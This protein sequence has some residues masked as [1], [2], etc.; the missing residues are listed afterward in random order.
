MEVLHPGPNSPSQ[1]TQRQPLDLFPFDRVREG[2]REFLRDAREALAQG[3]HLVAHAPTGIGKTAAALAASVEDAVAH[4]RKV[5]FMTAKHS[6]HRIAVETLQVMARRMP[7]LAVVDAISKQA[8][9]LYQNSFHYY[10][11]FHEF[12][13]FMVKSRSCRYYN[14]NS[15]EV[16]EILRRR[17]LHVQEAVA[18][19][20]DHGTCPHK[21]AMEAA[22]GAHVVVC[23]Y[24]YLFSDI[25][26]RILKHLGSGLRDLT[27]VVDEAHNLPD[28]I[29][30]QNSLELRPSDVEEAALEAHSMD[31]RVAQRLTNLHRL[32]GQA[33]GA[34]P[35]ETRVEQD[36]LMDP[37][38]T[39]LKL[40]LG[41]PPSPLEF[42]EEVADLG[43]RTVALG[44]S[45]R[46][47]D[48][49][50][51]LQRWNL[52]GDE[53]LRTASS[54]AGG[55]LN[56]I[57]LDPSVISREVFA[58][59]H[60]SILMSGTLHPGAMYADLLGL[61]E[62]RRLVRSYR[63][64]FPPANRPL[65]VTPHL[66]SLYGRRDEGLFQ[67]YARAIHEASAATQGNAAAFFPSYDFLARVLD[68]LR[69]LQPAKPLVVEGRDQ[70]KVQ[71]E[72]LVERLRT[73]RSNGGALLM[74]VMGGG[75]SEGVDYE[76]NLLSLVLVV[77]LP[78]S[79]PSV[80]VEA[81][82]EYYARRFGRSKA[83]EYAFLN[84]ALN[85]VLQAAGRCIRTEED[86]AVVALLDHRY[87]DPR[88]YR[89]LPEDFRPA[90]TVDLAGEVARFF[91]G[92]Q[93]GSPCA[94]EGRG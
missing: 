44:G 90:A 40:G 32:L 12:C 27:L 83:Y 20:R 61:E 7:S 6:Q 2:Q 85:K 49:A 43:Q 82:R 1:G 94:P 5:L 75:L 23:D 92:G 60:G 38:R 53:I 71:R 66:T 18:L 56:T 54:D 65:L 77:G 87:L 63:S 29:R 25:A 19:A 24:N 42:T 80:T 93:D 58:G 68:A 89:H 34:L 48:L 15:E 62:E 33:L 69:P 9:C 26:E 86:R 50:V 46:M 64:G 13:N 28:R 72:A 17:P 37:V 22:A 57:L 74:G 45:S 21:A 52:E 3:K 59:V 30:A 35:G 81:L 41:S 73:H 91:Y 51:F 10:G 39:S 31:R 79:P 67:E 11:A 84:P 4:D 47:L 76:D 36:I 55:I 88:Y 8:M 16:A 70:S 14:A 78:V